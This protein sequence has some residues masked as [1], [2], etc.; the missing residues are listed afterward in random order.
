MLY[1]L[2]TLATQIAFL[3]S[4][5]IQAQVDYMHNAGMDVREVVNGACRDNLRQYTAMDV[6]I[7]TLSGLLAGVVV[8]A[9]CLL[10][11]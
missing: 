2:L 11:M 4:L 9:V 1:R 7:H 8:L 6:V 10:V 3:E 5:T